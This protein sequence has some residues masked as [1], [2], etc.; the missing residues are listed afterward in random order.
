MGGRLRTLGPAVAAGLVSAAAFWWVVIGWVCP[1]C[2]SLGV[3][4]WRP[5]CVGWLGGLLGVALLALAF[6][7]PFRLVERRWPWQAA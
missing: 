4:T 1:E 2:D 6:A 3:C 7:I 5:P